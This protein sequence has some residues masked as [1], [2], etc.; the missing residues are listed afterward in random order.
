MSFF[1]DE[2]I[3]NT[4]EFR[5]MRSRI[6][7][8]V[9]SLFV[10]LGGACYYHRRACRASSAF[11]RLLT[12][13]TTIS[14]SRLVILD[15]DSPIVI[16]DTPSLQYLTAAMRSSQ[17]GSYVLGASYY[18]D[19]W[20]DSGDSIRCS[21]YVSKDQNVITVCFPIDTIQLDAMEKY[22]VTLPIPVPNI[23]Q[24]TLSE[25]RRPAH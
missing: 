20:L 4:L 24:S 25:L 13:D 17:A 16:E 1:L 21:I 2:V 14:I 18:V 6:L 8:C 10:V 22:L 12:G 3:A 23:L 5:C 15:S 11:E 7:L 9:V 19:L